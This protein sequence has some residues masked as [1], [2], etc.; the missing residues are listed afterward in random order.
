M[1]GRGAGGGRTSRLQ[2]FSHHTLPCLLHPY[3]TNQGQPTNHLQVLHKLH[4]AS[5]KRKNR[6]KQTKLS[7][8]KQLA[9]YRPSQLN[10]ALAGCSEK[11]LEEATPTTGESPQQHLPAGSQVP[12]KDNTKDKLVTGFFTFMIRLFFSW[13]KAFCQ[14]FSWG[15]NYEF[16][17]WRETETGPIN[18]WPAWGREPGGRGQA[19]LGSE[20]R[21]R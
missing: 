20:R 17:S 14:G 4:G 9:T 19:L 16:Q 2:Y 11:H 3:F 13:D 8:K 12:Y 15:K 21:P 10:C 5:N 7:G 18:R 1:G 6:D